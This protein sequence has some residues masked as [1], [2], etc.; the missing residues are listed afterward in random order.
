M[1]KQVLSKIPAQLF[2]YY[3]NVAVFYWVAISINSPS[4]A[5]FSIL[6]VL[7]VQEL[8]CK[9]ATVNSEI[10]HFIGI[11]NASIFPVNVWLFDK[12]MIYSYLTVL[13]FTLMLLPHPCLAVWWASATRILRWD[14]SLSWVKL[15]LDCNHRK[16][17]CN[18]YEAYLI[19]GENESGMFLPRLKR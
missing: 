8:S 1:G 3:F 16:Q 12:H 5:V 17:P 14:Y 19:T 11:E 9:K 15:L 10:N 18:S 13:T 6:V 4:L 2:P 7:T